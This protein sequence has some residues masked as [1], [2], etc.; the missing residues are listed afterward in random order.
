M[1]VA[2]LQKGQVKPIPDAT[3]FDLFH[4][5]R[6][7]MGDAEMQ[8]A[9]SK[10]ADSLQQE[11][12]LDVEVGSATVEGEDPFA[13]YTSSVI[14]GDAND[15]G[16]SVQGVYA[17]TL[18]KHFAFAAY[19]YSSRHEPQTKETLLAIQKLLLAD[20]VKANESAEEEQRQTRTGQ[21]FLGIDWH[22][23]LVKAIIA[24]F[25]AGLVG[26]IRKWAHG[27]KAKPS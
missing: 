15:P 12:I 6:Q 7:K 11:G 8:S 2:I 5:L 17:V 24:A 10:V 9:A 14:T 26:L 3:R 23:A 4:E 25:A 1:L 27:R 19:L 16:S 22:H 18:I 21:P 20:F 13:F